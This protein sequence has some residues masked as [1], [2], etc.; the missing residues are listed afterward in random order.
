MRCCNELDP[1]AESR[2]DRK[3]A[4]VY[5]VKRGCS[6]NIWTVCGDYP[7]IGSLF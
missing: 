2:G 3:R 1:P 6:G 7:Q 4:Y 5:L